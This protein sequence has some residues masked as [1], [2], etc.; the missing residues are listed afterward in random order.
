MK[1]RIKILKPVQSYIIGDIYRV[2]PH[3]AGKLI[4]R[5]QAEDVPNVKEAKVVIETKE[6]K[7]TPETKEAL[8]I[9]KL[10]KVISDIS[11]EEL[12]HIANFDKRITAVLMAKAE[13]TKR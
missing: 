1:R 8:S 2:S 9:S 6:E 3:F 7:F 12:I 10:K 5:G 13:L 4:S 11:V